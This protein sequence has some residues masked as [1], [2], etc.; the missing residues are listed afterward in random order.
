MNGRQQSVS[1]ALHD[2]IQAVPMIP[3][4]VLQRVADAIPV[5]EALMASGVSGRAAS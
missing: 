5:A 4:I 3:V 1:V 2:A